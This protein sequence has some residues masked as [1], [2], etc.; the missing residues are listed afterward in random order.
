MTINKL[1]FENNQTVY[2]LSLLLCYDDNYDERVEMAMEQIEN[3][4]LW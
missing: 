1:L 4:Y 2:P 3:K